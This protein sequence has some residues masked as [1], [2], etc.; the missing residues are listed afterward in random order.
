MKKVQINLLTKKDEKLV[1]KVIYFGLHYLRYIIVITQIVVI[2][3]FFY[4]FKIDQEII[5][6]KENVQQKKEIFKITQPL[7]DEATLITK[8]STFTTDVLARQNE[9]AT[10]TKFIFS[11]IPAEMI[12]TQFDLDDK[13]ITMQGISQSSNRIKQLTEVFKNSKNFKDV[14]ISTVEKTENGYNFTINITR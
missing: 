7:I 4:R 11:N 6:L 8:E 14:Q 3:V 1:N 9:F 5:D 13:K 12:L 10:D 2:G